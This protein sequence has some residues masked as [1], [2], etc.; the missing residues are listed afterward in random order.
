MVAEG[1]ERNEQMR[2]KWEV[3]GDKQRGV[4][5]AEVRHSADIQ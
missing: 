3:P 5:G 4:L 1:R 2:G